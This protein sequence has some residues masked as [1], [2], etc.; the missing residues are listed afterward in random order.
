MAQLD[1]QAVDAFRVTFQPVAGGRNKKLII[2]GDVPEMGTEVTL[3][4][5]PYRIVKIK[6][7][8]VIAVIERGKGI[9][10]VA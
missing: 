8:R 5:V 1:L 3:K 7:E 6:P 10:E 9:T 4:N 2:Q